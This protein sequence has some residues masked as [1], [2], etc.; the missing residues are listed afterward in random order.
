MTLRIAD[1]TDCFSERMYKTRIRS[2]QIQRNYRRKDKESILRLLAAAGTEKSSDSPTLT[3][4]GVPVKMH[5]IE[6]FR[7][8]QGNVQALG[9]AIAPYTR[10]RTTP[11]P[12]LRL[13]DEYHIPEGALFECHQYLQSR[14][15]HISSESHDQFGILHSRALFD[16]ARL[17]MRSRQAARDCHYELARTFLDCAQAYLTT[18]LRTQEIQLLRTFL[19]C[20]EF[21]SGNNC[22]ETATLFIDFTLKTIP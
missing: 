12:S 16:M 21:G 10:S 1:G 13:G 4:R 17:Y 6:R 8:S 3:L 22:F 7:R 11:T 19:C 14:L 20:L 18:A 5:K 2:W 9:A 15:E